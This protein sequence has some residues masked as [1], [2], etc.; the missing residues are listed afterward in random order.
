MRQTRGFHT[1]EFCG[2]REKAV[3]NAEIRV[4]GEGRM[5]AAPSLVHHYVV[6]HGYKPPEEF[7]AAVMAFPSVRI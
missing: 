4:P 1:C 5:Y 7:I 2:G 3:G 6:A